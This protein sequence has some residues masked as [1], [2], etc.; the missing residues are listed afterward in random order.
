MY[1]RVLINGR[2]TRV[3]SG[4]ATKSETTDAGAVYEYRDRGWFLR[5]I[6][7]THYSINLTAYVTVGAYKATVPLVTI[8]HNS[9]RSAGESFLRV[10]A[11]TVQ[12]FPLILVKGDGSNAVATV[13]FVVKAS[14]ETQSSVGALAIQA[15]ESV[16]KAVAPESSVV[17]TLSAQSARDRAAALDTA[18][19]SLMSKQL[20]E[21]Q[22]IDND[23]RRWGN[24]AQIDFQ[25]PPPDNEDTWDK[26]STFR[27][28][29]SWIV[30]FEDP[31]PSIFSDIQV[32]H[33]KMELMD[34]ATS[35]SDPEQAYCR[36]K[37]ADAAKAAQTDTAIRPEQVLAFNLLS[38]SQSLGSVSAYLK[39][40]SW[41]D[42][43]MKTFN[44]LKDD[45]PK[46]EDVSSFCKSIKDSLAGIGLNAI[47]GGIV[48]S[49][50]RD[51]AQLPTKVSAAMKTAD[52]CGY[53]A[54]PD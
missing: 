49:A 17:T 45:A 14:D 2:G 44:G 25:V 38:G 18:I 22:L 53:A 29:G 33:P 4:D 24:G 23:V 16:A 21:E 32:C 39:Q 47:D 11:H 42:A 30:T 43:S 8:D 35:K 27:T 9:N 34:E 28:V 51:R 31:R 54:F 36:A 37:I 3:R 6:W 40:Q 46:S 48:T 12:N 20:D 13:K 50:I 1:T 26:S 5:E 41:W 7:G 52:G 19:N 15:A 10:V